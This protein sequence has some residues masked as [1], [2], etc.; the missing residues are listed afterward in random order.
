MRVT[1]GV[2]IVIAQSEIWEQYSESNAVISLQYDN[3][4]RPEMTSSIFRKDSL[5]R[6]KRY[7]TKL[8]E[9]KVPLIHLNLAG[10]DQ[11]QTSIWESAIYAKVVKSGS[12]LHFKFLKHNPWSHSSWFAAVVLL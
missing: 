9:N 4:K 11:S 5:V 8:Y 6:F 1:N 2:T 3:H 7:T 12:L 10:I